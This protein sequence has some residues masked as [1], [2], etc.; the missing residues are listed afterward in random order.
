MNIIDI[1]IIA[2]I[3]A[4]V[5]FGLYRGFISSVG[6]TGG[7]LVAF[8]ASFHLYPTVAGF[9]RNS[10]PVQDLLRTYV[11][12]QIPEVG[13]GTSAA[14]AIS[15]LSL[16]RVITDWLTRNLPGGL[17][18]TESI[19]TYVNDSLVSA[20]MNILSF[21]VTFILLYVAL[22]LVMSA[23]RAIF[24]LPVLKQMDTAAGG[25]F[26]LL[27]GVVF[28]FVIF[29]LLPVAQS[30]VPGDTV[31][32]LVNGSTLAGIFDS[33]ALINAVLRGSLFG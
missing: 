3:G 21:V 4:S 31:N 19:Q 6:S 15:G 2:V 14:E 24:K 16:P 27:R 33:G 11:G 8:V 20:C 23:L 25:I 13:A 29:T 17:G 1:G 26:G 30:L 22:A 18:G 32:D 9:I 5:L 7:A 10:T 28:V 12:A